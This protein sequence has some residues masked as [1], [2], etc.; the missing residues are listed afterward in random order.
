[1][2]WLNLELDNLGCLMNGWIVGC[3]ESMVAHFHAG[4]LIDRVW[5]GV[6]W[7]GMDWQW[8]GMSDR[9]NLGF[10]VWTF[11]QTFLRMFE[12]WNPRMNDWRWT[13]KRSF[14]TFKRGHLRVIRVEMLNAQTFIPNVR[15]LGTSGVGSETSN[16]RTSL[17]YVRTIDYS[18]IGLER[19]FELS[20]QGFEPSPFDWCLGRFSRP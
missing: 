9:Q 16:V 3:W 14:W 5:S 2:V 7:F 17:S 1:M 20:L 10:C 4:V 6:E 18:V 15:T 12:C 13:F 8:F 19:E 11:L